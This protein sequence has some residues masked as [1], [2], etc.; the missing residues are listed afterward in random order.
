MRSPVSTDLTEEHPMPD[1]TAKPDPKNVLALLFAF[2]LS[3]TMFEAVS[4]GD[5][6]REPTERAG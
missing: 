2:R 6:R 5:P 4:L 3:K 1:Q